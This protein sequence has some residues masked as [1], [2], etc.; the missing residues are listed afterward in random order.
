MSLDSFVKTAKISLELNPNCCR[1]PPRPELRSRERE[2]KNKHK[3]WSIFHEII[4][5]SL[6]FTCDDTLQAHVTAATGRSC[7]TF[8]HPW[9]RKGRPKR[10]RRAIHATATKSKRQ[11][12]T[13]ATTKT[14]NGTADSGESVFV[15]ACAWVD[16]RTF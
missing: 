7:T 3:N 1:N 6:Y 2:K 12:P 10:W 16:C 15:R 13:S 8:R 9:P 5:T 11:P 4:T 14:L